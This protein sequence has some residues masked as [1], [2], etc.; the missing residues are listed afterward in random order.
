MTKFKAFVKNKDTKEYVTIESEYKSK[1]SFIKDLRANG[2]MVNPLKVK[3]SE[4]FDY[5]INN[6]NCYE[7]DW[8][9]NN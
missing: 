5:I 8:K 9:E 3:K 4:V 2:Y 7:W 6:T 1:E